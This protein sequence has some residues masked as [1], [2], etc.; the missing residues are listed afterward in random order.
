MNI[1]D[2]FDRGAIQNA[3]R[4]CLTDGKQSLSYCEVQDY[5]HRIGLGLRA[6]GI[7]AEH[8]IAVYSPNHINGF[9]VQL[10]LFRLGATYIPI[11]ARNPVHDNIDFLQMTGVDW[12]FYHSSFTLK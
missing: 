8:K 1:I 11:N 10:G 6:N 7:G 3:D 12:L 2:F 9:M 5:S 4:C